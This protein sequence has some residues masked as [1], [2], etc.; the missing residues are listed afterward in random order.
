MPEKTL[1]EKYLL[2]TAFEK[3]IVL[4]TYD[5]GVLVNKDISVLTY[6]LRIDGKRILKKLE[7][8]FAFPLEKYQDIKVGI[9]INEKIAAEQHKPIEDVEDRPVIAPSEY[10]SGTGG[11]VKITLRTGH[12]LN[13]YQIYHTRYNIILR[14]NSK[15]VLVYKHG[16]LEYDI[17]NKKI[18]EG[19]AHVRR[20]TE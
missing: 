14:V 7:V 11:N 19:A 16:V 5:G 20:K 4:W 6:D 15:V 12:I 13:G 9:R 2:E 18:K 3:P 10:R 17:Q 1:T 8:M